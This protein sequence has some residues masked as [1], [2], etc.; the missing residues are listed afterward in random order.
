MFRHSNH[1]VRKL[2]HVARMFIVRFLPTAFTGLL[3]FKLEL[4]KPNPTS[5]QINE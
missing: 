1:P 2:S 3:S 5:I 4:S